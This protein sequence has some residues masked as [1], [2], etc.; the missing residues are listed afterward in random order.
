MDKGWPFLHS[1]R[2]NDVK[3]TQESEVGA[4]IT[5]HI[6]SRLKLPSFLNIM[7][8]LDST[9]P[10]PHY[11]HLPYAREPWKSG[12]VFMRLTTTL[13]M[14]PWWAVYYTF[15]PRSVRP[16][17]S[18]NLRQCIYV[19]FIRRVF[20]VTEVAGVTWG[21][22]DPTLE[23]ADITLS[24]TTWE[25]A[26]PLKEEWRTG[27]IKEGAPFTRVGC[28]I[29]PRQAKSMKDTIM[30]KVH[31]KSDVGNPDTKA[32]VDDKTYLVGIFMHGGGY[33]HMSAH[34]SS[35]TSRIP[36]GLIK[37]GILD[38]V[39]SV[40]YRLLQIAPFPAVVQDAAAVYQHVLEKYETMGKKCKIILCGDS[41]GGN[42]VLALTRWLR[43]EGH[44]RMPDGLILLSPSC[45][46]S[47]DLPET[48]SSYIP[49]PNE[50]SDYLVDNPEPRALLQRT[51]LGFPKGGGP[52]TQEDERRL[53]QIGHSEYVSPCSPIVLERWGHTV[54][55]DPE[56]QHRRDFWKEVLPN[57]PHFMKLYRTPNALNPMVRTMTGEPWDDS[58][59][60][61]R[62]SCQFPS[63]FA[64]F[65]KTIVVCG[66]GER[67]VREVRAL[68]AAMSKDGVDIT[69]YWAPDACHDPLMINE[70][71]W[72]KKVLNSIWEEIAKWTASGFNGDDT[73]ISTLV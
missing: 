59:N 22:R 25:W 70:N 60:P 37:R 35:R 32:P 48:L 47:H 36:R 14:V 42:L 3:E 69:T 43:D 64:A 15:M 63:L 17:A 16:R 30:D 23:P 4:T 6:T 54:V 9:P 57:L 10:Y 5:P 39:Y 66:D 67:L 31:R 24:E 38:E 26:E 8:L 40:E 12:Y 27:I 44:M 33:C 7:P 45:D 49:R 41:S 53:M 56:G 29:W 72:D 46:T 50:W 21:T 34:E 18:W 19:N 58:N 28:Y 1:S 51:F 68:V 71:W 62:K 11:E 61:Y 52:T 20:K 55:Q 65:P 2:E 73:K 13:L